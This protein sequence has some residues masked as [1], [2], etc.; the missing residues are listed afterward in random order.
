MTY[1]IATLISCIL[2]PIFGWFGTWLAKRTIYRPITSEEGAAR[3][4]QE[5]RDRVKTIREKS[6]RKTFLY[7]GVI[8][9]VLFAMAGLA[10]PARKVKAALFPTATPTITLTFTSTVTRTPSNT[11]KASRTP[12]PG[13]VQSDNFLTALAGTPITGTPRTP[14]PFLP[15]GSTSN[16][17][18]QRIVQTVIVVRTQ[19]VYIPVT[20]INYY[21]VTVL[22]PVTVTNTPQPTVITDTPSPTLTF[23]Q[24]LSPTPTFTPTI[25]E[26]PTP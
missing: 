19:I 7:Y 20:Q 12:T 2:F 25:T 11:P 4:E 9:L 13:G 10:E 17:S 24:T 21:P 1:G 15:S 16:S 6:V 14:T 23:T 26:T 5:E 22:V 3:N 18:P 8:V